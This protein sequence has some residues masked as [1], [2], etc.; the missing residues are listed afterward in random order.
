MIDEKP[1]LSEWEVYLFGGRTKDTS[2][3]WRPPKGK[4]PCW[5]WRKMQWLFFGNL[6]VK[7]KK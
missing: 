7:D 6:W 4:H 1:E 3:A 2:I 5:F